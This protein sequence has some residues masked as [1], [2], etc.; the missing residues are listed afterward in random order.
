MI[1]SAPFELSSIMP[2]YKFRTMIDMRFLVLVNSST[3]RSLYL[4][5]E[6][7]AALK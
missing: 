2:V 1:E 5:V 4:Q 6:P 3:S 7:L